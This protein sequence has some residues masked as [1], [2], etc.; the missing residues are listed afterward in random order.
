MHHHHQTQKYRGLTAGHLHPRHHDPTQH[1]LEIIHRRSIDGITANCR[2]SHHVDY[3]AYAAQ[4]A[5]GRNQGM[6]ALPTGQLPW[7]RGLIL[8]LTFSTSLDRTT[9]TNFSYVCRLNSTSND[10]WQLINTPLCFPLYSTSVRNPFHCHANPTGCDRHSPA[11][12]SVAHSP[13]TKTPSTQIHFSI[14]QLTT[15]L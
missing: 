8:W 6:P 13:T 14:W 4:P 15:R 1:P 12:N 10:D 11:A 3:F 9:L 2:N 7:I 5:Q